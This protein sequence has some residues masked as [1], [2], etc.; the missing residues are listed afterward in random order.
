M[1]SLHQQWEGP[2]T[3][4][5][6]SG[7]LKQLTAG[8]SGT[9]SHTSRAAAAALECDWQ[10]LVHGCSEHTR[11]CPCGH[12]RAQHLQT[13]A[14]IPCGVQQN[15]RAATGIPQKHNTLAHFLVQTP[16][17][18]RQHGQQHH[19]VPS[20]HQQHTPLPT[21]PCWLATT[22]ACTCPHEHH[23]RWLRPHSSEVHT[24]CL[25][26]AAG[27]SPLTLTRTLQVGSVDL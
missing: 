1:D 10:F 20:W 27:A 11:C 15:W 12:R 19:T 24:P 22:H 3:S 23:K 25:Q 26:D 18:T 17:S 16:A 13:A 21:Q 6:S 8:P 5:C 7:G 2:T 14:C 9:H 4:G